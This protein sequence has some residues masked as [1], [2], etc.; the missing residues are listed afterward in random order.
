MNAV[1]GDS[2]VFIPMQSGVVTAPQMNG[3]YL[4]TGTMGGE[5]VSI[6]KRSLQVQQLWKTR[7]EFAGQVPGIIRSKILL[8]PSGGERQLDCISYNEASVSG[9][10][11]SVGFNHPLFVNT[12]DFYAAMPYIRPNASSTDKQSILTIYVEDNGRLS[13]SVDVD[14][15][16]IPA[17]PLHTSGWNV[18]DLSGAVVVEETGVSNASLFHIIKVN[19]STGKV[20]IDWTRTAPGTISLCLADPVMTDN[21]II[22]RIGPQSIVAIDNKK[23]T[24]E[25]ECKSSAPMTGQ[26]LFYEN[27]LVTR[28][29]QDSISVFS[30]RAL[31]P[32]PMAYAL[33]QNFPNPFKAATTILYELPLKSRVHIMVTDMEG[34]LVATLVNEEKEAGYYRVAWNA[35]GTSNNRL[36]AGTYLTRITAG[37]F[38]RTIQMTM[39]R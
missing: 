30:S 28:T 31:T 29:I 36:A 13:S 33:H 7:G 10:N 22:A 4:L 32:L 9:L 5:L 2:A 12:S 20:Q 3:P 14:N 8:A 24:L 39:I 34:R 17:G 11:W 6:D 35:R 25:W 27:Y 1:S 37:L 18:R 38:A 16:F 19:G 15:T 26:V 21:S 23:G